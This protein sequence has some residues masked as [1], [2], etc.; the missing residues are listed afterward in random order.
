MSTHTPALRPRLVSAL[1]ASAAL[2]LATAATAQQAYVNSRTHLRAGPDRGY[3][4]V[5][6]LSA[7]SGVY[8]HGCVRGYHWCDVSSGP[9]RGWA[10]ARHLNYLY[11]GRQVAIYGYGPRIG[12]PIVGY[13]AG[14]YWDS[15]Y[16]DR[17]F[18]GRR[19][20]WNSWHPGTPAPRYSAPPQQPFVPAPR[21]PHFVQPLPQ[22]Q[23]QFR[24][25]PPAYVA[26]QQRLT[27]NHAAPHSQRHDR[28][29]HNQPN[30]S[31]R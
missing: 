7:G 30:G 27:P 29:H 28:P 11:Q 26:P 21:Q 5:A 9:V 3:P 18:Y 2:V 14:T 12:L 31:L 17:P 1:A 24:S 15:Y 22:T 6:W 19:D 16:R 8:V 4:Q 10:N 20:Y 23:P 13:S 25:Q